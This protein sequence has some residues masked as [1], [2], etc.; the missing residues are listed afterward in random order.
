[1]H[2]IISLFQRNYDGDCLV[3]DGVV[4][5]AEWVLAGEGIATRKWDGMAAM[6]RD[7]RLYKRYNFKKGK[8]PPPMFEPIQ[9]PDP[10]TGYWPG[11]LPVGT[12]PEDKWFRDAPINGLPYGTYEL[13]GPKIQGNAEHLMMHILLPHGKEILPNAPRTF[14]ELRTWFADRDI[15]GIVWWHPDGRMVKIKKRDFYGRR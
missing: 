1:M 5:G 15:E 4:Y 12:G 2:K 9:D 3:R 7:G 11:W 6:L 10:V 13:C 14:T 8:Q